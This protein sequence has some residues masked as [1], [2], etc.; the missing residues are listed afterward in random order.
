V[1]KAINVR[2]Y[3]DFLTTLFL[4]FGVLMEFPILLVGLL[5]RR[6]RHLGATA[7]QRGGW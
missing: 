7:P 4:A 6:H 5:A 1:K 2:S 3:F